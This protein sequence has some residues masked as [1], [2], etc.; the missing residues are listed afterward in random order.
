MTYRIEIPMRLPGMNEIIAANRLNRQGG[1]RQKREVQFDIK[2][3]AM[4]LPELK[5]PCDFVFDWYEPNRKRDKDN[6]AAGKK[7]ILD[8]LQELGKLQNDGWS[9][10]GNFADRFFVDKENPRVEVIIYDQS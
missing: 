7:F 6:I 1:A 9:D 2:L 4:N 10:I 5:P 8:A 3:V